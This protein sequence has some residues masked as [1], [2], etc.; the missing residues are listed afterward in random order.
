MGDATMFG[1]EIPRAEL[2]FLRMHPESLPNITRTRYHSHSKLEDMDVLIIELTDGKLVLLVVRNARN[3]E[4]I[5][6]VQHQDSRLYQV[7]MSLDK[8]LQNL[9]HSH[10][11]IIR[12]KTYAEVLL[13]RVG[14]NP[15][16]NDKRK[17]KKNGNQ[18]KNGDQKHGHKK[19]DYK[20]DDSLLPPSKESGLEGYAFKEATK[21]IIAGSLASGAVPREAAKVIIRVTEKTFTIVMQRVTK[22]ICCVAV[23]DGAGIALRV[24]WGEITGKMF[25]A[26]VTKRVITAEISVGPTQQI[27]VG[28][29]QQLT[30]TAAKEAA[31]ETAEA[32]TTKVGQRM[33]SGAK[34]G[35]VA[36]VLV[37]GL[38]LGYSAYNAWDKEGDEFKAHME[39]QALKSGGS[40]AGGTIGAAIG[41]VIFPGFGTF[42]GN[43]IGS[44]A[45]NMVVSKW[46]G[47]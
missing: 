40:L 6:F 26:A 32:T 38:S 18:K 31:K 21:A 16:R 42:A 2:N 15:H 23:N 10:E 13:K 28:P 41:T 45:G 20:N 43:L 22:R 36:G 44:V 19:D 9:S 4:V 17:Q 35:L 3:K 14:V 27:I 1:D 11:D 29:T 46:C 39:K 12:D 30:K 47:D 5:C 37:E 34:A 7:K 24:V 25:V 33:L 8:V